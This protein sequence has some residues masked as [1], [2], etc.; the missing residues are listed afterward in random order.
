M[1]GYEVAMLRRNRLVIGAVSLAG[2]GLAAGLWMAGPAS[3][4]SAPSVEGRTSSG[5][6]TAVA[7]ST[8]ATSPA[9]SGTPHWVPAGTGPP[10]PASGPPRWAPAGSGPPPVAAVPAVASTS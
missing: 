7:V 6:G 3:A 10:P 5:S 4:S 2:V 9:P 8:P 1:K